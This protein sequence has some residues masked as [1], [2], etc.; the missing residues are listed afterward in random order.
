GDGSR[1]CRIQ[2]N[3]DPQYVAAYLMH[4]RPGRGCY[5]NSSSPSHQLVH[6]INLKLDDV[7]DQST[8]KQ[9][10]LKIEPKDFTRIES[11]DGEKN[12]VEVHERPLVFVLNS[13]QPVKWKVEVSNKFPAHNR[14]L[15][16]IPKHST[17]RFKKRRNGAQARGRRR[18]MPTALD[19]H[20]F[21]L[22]VKRRFKAVT[23]YSEV[24]GE[25][26]LFYVGIAE[27][28]SS[29]CRL[30]EMQPSPY[31]LM[32]HMERQAV[33][34]CT[35]TGMQNVLERPVYII[36]LLDVPPHV[37]DA[38]KQVELDIMSSSGK[39][40]EH[41]FY[42]VLRSPESIKW[43]LRS[44]R[45]Q[46]W[47]DVVSDADVDLRGIRMHTVALRH[48]EMESTGNDLINW[49]EYYVAPV[50]AYTA[51]TSAN[52]I[53]LLLPSLDNVKGN[54]ALPEND[55]VLP[56]KSGG[57]S[58]RTESPST[59]MRDHLRHIIL[60]RC[61]EGVMEATLPTF[62]TQARELDLP[63]EQLSLLDGSCRATKN[64]THVILRT[65]LDKCQTRKITVDDNDVYSNAIVIHASGMVGAILEE[66]LGSGYFDLQATSGSGWSETGVEE[67][68]A[69]YV[70]DEDFTAHKVEIDIECQ[71]PKNPAPAPDRRPK[72]DVDEQPTEDEPQ[73]E[74]RMYED[75]FYLRRVVN[76][77]FTV[78][79]FHGVYVFATAPSERGAH[80]LIENCW[81]TRWADPHTPD[82]D[83]IVL[84][85][86]GCTHSDGAKWFQ[87]S[88]LSSRIKVDKTTQER[89]IINKVLP[90]NSYLHC[91]LSTCRAGE[92]T[93]GQKCPPDPHEFCDSKGMPKMFLQRNSQSC[94]V[95]TIGPLEITNEIR[96]IEDPTTSNTQGTK[97]QAGAGNGNGGESKAT[98]SGSHSGA[99]QSVIIEGLD[100]G[101]VVGI[102]FAA[103]AIGI[104]LTG[105]LWFIHTH[106]G[107][108]KRG[109]SSVSM[110]G[111]SGDVTPNSSS[112]ISA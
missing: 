15:Y 23:S 29:E 28:S 110:V 60:T 19:E 59:D 22:W 98:S 89:L 77:P 71:V 94:G 33:S 10:V 31:A 90:H 14:Q 86:K 36:E 101:T 21:L 38:G 81:V 52:I 75:P 108:S 25:K 32:A 3:F 39:E 87:Y 97:P 1:T 80:V 8:R 56:E 63:I 13:E 49:A 100:S 99:E 16:L 58:L 5:S 37:L 35:S 93:L 85:Q 107:P 45:I 11:S 84:V 20:Q 96:I 4:Y 112:P 48:E 73:C 62:L 79:N 26:L 61:E 76:F 34:G 44:H 106:T 17:I 111:T 83:Q 51:V 82:T 72:Q 65:D 54:E 88:Q 9:V 104:L 41:D 55:D 30:N 109:M 24:E 64:R 46:G 74:M 50:R 7:T 78:N 69:T 42:L 95:H 105:A 6:V 68:D 53:Q 18:V 47:I 12:S 66:E 92:E 70:D 27:G 40:I 91:Q 57:P 2:P 43:V 102:A 103:F 67:A